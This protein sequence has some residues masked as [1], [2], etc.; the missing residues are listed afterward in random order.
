MVAPSSRSKA[1]TFSGSGVEFEG[2]NGSR[3]RARDAGTVAITVPLTGETVTV[4]GA[5]SASPTP[6]PPEGVR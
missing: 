4:S 1:A 3:I 6:G 5:A 2:K